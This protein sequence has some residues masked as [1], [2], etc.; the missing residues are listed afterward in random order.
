MV[1]QA[2]PADDRRQT[3]KAAGQL[4]AIAC[5]SLGAAG[6]TYLIKGPP[7]RTFICDPGHA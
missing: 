1:Q 4:A 6:G 3:M 7:A 2:A 5:I